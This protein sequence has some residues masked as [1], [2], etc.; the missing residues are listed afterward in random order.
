VQDFAG[1]QGFS[2]FFSGFAINPLDG[3]AS[4]IHLLGTLLLSETL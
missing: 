3:A 1:Y 4:D 2:Q